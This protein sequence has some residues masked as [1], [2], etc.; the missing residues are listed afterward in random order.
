MKRVDTGFGSIYKNQKHK[1]RYSDS[2][3]DTLVKNRQIDY[4]TSSTKKKRK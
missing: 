3:T 1:H 2:D 4:R